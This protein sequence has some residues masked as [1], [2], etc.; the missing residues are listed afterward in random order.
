LPSTRR[1]LQTRAAVDELVY[2]MIRERRHS[3]EDR[4]DLLQMLMDARDEETGESMS[5]LQLHDELISMIFAGHETVS[6]CLTW[7][8]YLL[9]RNSCIAERLYSELDEVLGGRTPTVDDIP[10]L[11]YTTMLIQE[12][13]RLYPPIW[14]V[15]RT[16]LQD[17]EIGGFHIPAK[18]MLFLVPYVTHRHPDFW[19]NP[20]GVDPERFTPER[21]AGRPRY[22]WFPFGGGPRQCIGNSFAL[23][24]M[25]LIVATVAQHFR[26]N[27]VEGHKVELRPMV[28][29]RPKYGMRM[30]IEKRERKSEGANA[31][32]AAAAPGQ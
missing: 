27:L 18:S 16:N 28:T 12:A 7:T 5:D 31:Q 26:L 17:D 24:E 10:R 23:L 21:S 4:G 22:A 30:I 25:Q 13:L 8:W 29:L 19:E 11:S 14:L 20:E 6:T 2:R 3:T 32:V 9:S 15:P 1:F